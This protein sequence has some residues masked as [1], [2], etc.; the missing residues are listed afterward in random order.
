MQLIQRL[1]RQLAVAG[2]F[3]HRKVHITIAGLISQTFADQFFG[4]VQH[5]RHEV[6]G[7]RVVVGTGNAERIKVLVHLNNHALGQ[8]LDGFAIFDC[9]GNDLVVNV[10]NVAHKSHRI[11]TAAQPALDKVKRHIGSGVTDVTQVIHR[12]A[13]H[14]HAHVAGVQRRKFFHASTQRVVNANAHG[15]QGV[16]AWFKAVNTRENTGRTRHWQVWLE[17]YPSATIHQYSQSAC[18]AK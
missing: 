13:A 4:D 18:Q 17:L 6:C 16:R 1:A 11:T 2:E 12:H 5:L 7:A 9:S 15:L 3:A 10:S 8:R 14:I